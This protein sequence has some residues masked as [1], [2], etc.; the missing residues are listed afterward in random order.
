MRVADLLLASALASVTAHASAAQGA[1]HQLVCRGVS[2][3][4][5][6]VDQDPSPRNKAS[7]TMVLRYRRATKPTGQDVRLLEPGTCTWNPFGYAS[8]KPEPGF[9]LMFEVRGS[10]QVTRQ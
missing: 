7:V 4:S 9:V 6:E 8:E 10:I 3:I 2:G 5:L 1:M